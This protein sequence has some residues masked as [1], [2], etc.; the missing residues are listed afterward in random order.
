M[1]ATN[2]KTPTLVVH[3]QLDYRLDVQRRL[4]A[5]HHAAAPEH[6]LEDAALCPNKLVSSRRNHFIRAR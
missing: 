4:P 3:G 2:F 6:S 1:Y 5:V